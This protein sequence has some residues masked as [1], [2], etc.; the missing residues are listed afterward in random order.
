MFSLTIKRPAVC[1]HG[2]EYNQI[3]W[4]DHNVSFHVRIAQPYICHSSQGFPIPQSRSYYTLLNFILPRGSQKG[5]LYTDHWEVK[6]IS[7]FSQSYLRISMSWQYCYIR[8]EEKMSRHKNHPTHSTEPIKSIQSFK[9]KYNHSIQTF[10][11]LTT[12]FLV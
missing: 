3:Q 4:C 8:N 1:S 11:F 5:W 9:T 7:N 2:G 12:T 6:S 10:S